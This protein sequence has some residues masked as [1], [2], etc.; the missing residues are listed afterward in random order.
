MSAYR[1][2]FDETRYISFLIKNDKL[3]ENEIWEKV[4]N[5]LKKEFDSEPVYNKKYLKAKIK[6]YN[7]KINTNFHNNKIPKGSSQYICL[8]VILLD[9]GFRTGKNYSPQV[10]LEECKYVVKEKKI[11]KYIIDNIEISSD[12]DEENSDEENFDEEN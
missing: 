6:S 12:S 10:F 9:S 4:K 1:K 3:L 8:S 2:D 7:G 5:I 11:P